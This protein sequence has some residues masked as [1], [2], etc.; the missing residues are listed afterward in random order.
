MGHIENSKDSHRRIKKSVIELV[1]SFRDKHYVGGSQDLGPSYANHEKSVVDN[2]LRLYRLN[3]KWHNVSPAGKTARKMKSIC[4]MLAY[5]DAGVT[6]F[7]FSPVYG[8]DNRDPYVKSLFTQAHHDLTK[9]L[10]RHYRFD[11]SRVR[12]PS[13]ESFISAGGDVSL[14][15]KLRDQ[16][17]WTVTADCFEL[18]AQLVYAVPGLK[19]CAKTFFPDLS[20][21]E[22]ALLHLAYTNEEGR[23]DGFGVFRELFLEVV[24][25][26]PGMRLETVPKDNEK[27]RVIAC[28]PFLNML[29]QSVV[30]EGIRH[31]IKIH[32]GIDLKT[33]QK[34]HALL[35][36]DLSNAT[37]DLTN[38][39]N[40]FFVA[41][42]TALYRGS[43]L[44]ED[45]MQSRSPVA[46]LKNGDVEVNHILKMVSPMG[47]GFTFG[48][49]TL[50]ILALARQLDSFSHVYG[51]DIIID[52]DCAPT[53][54]HMLEL[55]GCRTN[56][57]K[58]FL[59]GGFRESCGS[60]YS[61][62]HYVLSYE[63]SYPETIIDCVTITNKIGYIAQQVGGEWEALHNDL[64]LAWD[65]IYYGYYASNDVM[66]YEPV[67]PWEEDVESRFVI[68]YS[69]KYMRLKRYNAT[70]R[71][72]WRSET[73]RRKRWLSKV[74]Y[75][76]FE[77]SATAYL[78]Y[79]KDNYRSTPVDSDT[80][81]PHWV[82]YWLYTG[83]CSAP[84]RR[85]QKD[86]RAVLTTIQLIPYRPQPLEPR[87]IPGDRW[88]A[89]AYQR[90]S[91]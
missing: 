31:V 32:Y 66:L 29:V 51:D 4:A 71:E 63:F 20:P 53:L 57:T 15:A 56:D 54:I 80:L 30:E 87:R 26:V 68:V 8:P 21:S 19:R 76:P 85:V 9:A 48:L 86:K 73:D 38:A 2:Y 83:R 24:D 60:F 61:T 44:I 81:N 59:T 1:T 55:I 34:L 43:Q 11:P 16:S 25:I 39:S 37:V 12:I 67:K 5:D 41:P 42:L 33:S 3:K 79:S 17:Q 35:I 40:S 47:N 75:E 72:I 45:V 89:H 82:S 13:G 64:L 78:S 91:L 62:D 74:Q 7:S 22:R 52:A 77:L 36:S 69:N 88:L 65:P 6:S 14:C 70:A 18:A 27:D 28:E 46:T 58:T 23:V 84:E 90:W 10:S 50:T 49:M